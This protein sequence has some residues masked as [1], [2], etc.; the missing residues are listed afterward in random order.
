MLSEAFKER[1][2]ACQHSG[3]LRTSDLGIGLRDLGA[4][5]VQNNIFA[6]TYISIHIHIRIYTYIYICIFLLHMRCICILCY[7][8]LVYYINI[9]VRIYA[10][11]A[12]ACIALL[13]STVLTTMASLSM[14]QC[15]RAHVVPIQGFCF[16]MPYL[17]YDLSVYM[18]T[19][20]YL[21]MR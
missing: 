18:Y 10:A 3:C 8:L 15:Q 1:C 9:Y 19:Q 14:E 21:E 7:M 6:Y 20:T 4:L 13:V 16:Q 12:I 5:Y 2:Q 17:V 11:A